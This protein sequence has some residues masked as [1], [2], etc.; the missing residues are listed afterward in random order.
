MPQNV[1]DRLESVP[2]TTTLKR[3]KWEAF[4]FTVCSNGIVNVMNVSYGRDTVGHTYSVRLD[5]GVPIACSCP[6]YEHRDTSCKHMV[7]V[8]TTEVVRVA[9]TAA[10]GNIIRTDNRKVMTDGG[11]K[12]STFTGAWHP[13]QVT[14][15]STEVNDLDTVSA[16]KCV[17]DGVPADFPCWPC[18]RDGRKNLP[19]ND[20]S[21]AHTISGPYVDRA[22]D[23]S[24]T[25]R[26]YYCCDDCGKEAMTRSDLEEFTCE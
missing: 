17:C 8:A 21:H 3:A 6:Y 9:A 4:E 26:A 1:L 15:S 25:K 18:Y 14:L 20:K 23:G 16:E 22:N 12:Q 19:D 11:R 24:L 7:A 13:Q 2:S 10:A 5:D